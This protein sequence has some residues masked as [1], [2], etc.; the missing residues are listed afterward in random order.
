MAQT[1]RPIASTTAPAV[2]AAIKGGA[3]SAAKGVEIVPAQ[4][5]QDVTSS[6]ATGMPSD[7]TGR[8]ANLAFTLPH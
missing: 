8:E 3:K 4:Q 6:T 1:G 7:R 2:A 5:P